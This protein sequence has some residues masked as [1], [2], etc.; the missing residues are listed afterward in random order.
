MIQFEENERVAG[1]V[2]LR[3]A[4]TT[5]EFEAYAHPHGVRVA[6]LADELAK[7]FHLARADRSALLFAALSHDIGEMTMKRDYIKR[8]GSLTEEERVD[9]ARH[10][11]I[12]EQE[13]A[14]AGASRGTQLLVRWHHEWWNGAGYPDALRGEQIP[15]AARLL[16]VADAYASL[17]DARPFRPARTEGEARAHLAEWAGIEFDPRVTRAFLAIHA[18]P[19][20][21][22][23][24]GAAEAIA[25]RPE[26]DEQRVSVTPSILGL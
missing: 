12:G 18:L 19:E 11:V 13:A 23:Y 14:R 5:D 15:L 4:G 10:P 16:R 8:N 21:R 25:R 24:A 1:E 7:A 20:P 6:R 17:T 3:L 26:M 9:L 2:F 22:S